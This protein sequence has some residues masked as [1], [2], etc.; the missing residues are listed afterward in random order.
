MVKTGP[1]GCDE[2]LIDPVRFL[3]GLVQPLLLVGRQQPM[4]LLDLEILLLLI[5]LV[6][7][8]LQLKLLRVAQGLGRRD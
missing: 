1:E 2:H 4:G 8:G 3:L 6:A 7:I 5:Q